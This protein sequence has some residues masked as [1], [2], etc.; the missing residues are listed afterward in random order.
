MNAP[1]W[2][3]DAEIAALSP[4]ELLRLAASVIHNGFVGGEWAAS[5]PEEISYAA[6]REHGE[7]MAVLRAIRALDPPGKG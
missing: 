7:A 1:G 6:A 4:A 5:M 3:F 2:S